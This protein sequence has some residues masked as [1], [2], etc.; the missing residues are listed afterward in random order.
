[1]A[2]GKKFGAVNNTANIKA[3]GPFVPEGQDMPSPETAGNYRITVDFLTGQYK[4]V[5]I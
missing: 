2:W 3:G 4:V 1:M 5:K